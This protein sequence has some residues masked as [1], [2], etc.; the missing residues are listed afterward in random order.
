MVYDSGNMILVGEDPV[1]YYDAFADRI[2]HI[3]LKDMRIADA[4][5]MFTDRA[6]D[7]RAMTAAPTGTGL[8]DLENVMKHVREHGYDGYLTIEFAVDAEKDYRGTLRKSREY[9]ESLI[10]G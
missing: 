1:E 5:E 4:H 6:L 7:G 2:A 8:I 9:I 10:A 3:H